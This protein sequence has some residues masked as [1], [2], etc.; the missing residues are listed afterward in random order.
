M[1]ASTVL[2]LILPPFLDIPLTASAIAF[3]LA[4]KSAPASLIA[5]DITLSTSDFPPDGC[6]LSSRT[7]ISGALNSRP[8]VLIPLVGYTFFLSASTIPPSCPSLLNTS[9]QL[10][11]SFSMCILTGFF[12]LIAFGY[13]SCRSESTVSTSPSTSSM[14]YTSPPLD[15]SV[16]PSLSIGSVNISDNA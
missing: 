6:T 9:Y 2:A 10:S 15:R 3:L 16:N 11:L 7:S 4:F 1:I 13:D 12:D 5:L 14:A 8:V